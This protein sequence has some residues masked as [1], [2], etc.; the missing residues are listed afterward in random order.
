MSIFDGLLAERKKN[1][2]VIKTIVLINI[3]WNLEARFPIIKETVIEETVKKLK[4]L[5]NF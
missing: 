2:S 5:N 4:E 3:L 1:C